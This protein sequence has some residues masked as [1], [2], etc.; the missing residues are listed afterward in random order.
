M[1]SNSLL[2]LSRSKIA[3]NESVFEDAIRFI[4][5]KKGFSPQ[6]LYQKSPREL[7]NY[8]SQIFTN[9]ITEGFKQEETPQ[10]EASETVRNALRENVFVFSGMKTYQE[11]KEASL[12]LV[13]DKG[14]IKPF[15]QFKEDVKSVYQTYN[16]RYLEA[17]YDFAVHSSAMAARWQDFEEDAEE[18]DLQYRTAG[19]DKVRPEHAALNGI[20][21][22]KNDPFW[23]EYLPPNGWECRCTTVQVRKGKY[24]L[25]NPEESQ[26]LGKAA[27]T[28]KGK[29]GV[30][31]AAMFRFNSGKTLK[32]FPHKHPYFARQSS[33]QDVKQAQKVVEGMSK[34]IETWTQVETKKGKVRIS[35][36]HGKEEERENIKIA[37][38]LAN[39]HR[40]EIDLIAKNDKVK[41]SRLVQQNTEH[42]SGIQKECYSYPLGH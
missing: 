2:T 4:H 38:Y 39:K 24:P 42:V 28:Q 6:D 8:L 7:V 17:E 32:I 3:F 14:E 37:T 13:T 19:D 12:L 16:E 15:G 40:Y 23:N 9:S 30:N 34:K 35:S 1:Y 31:K 29:D 5:E 26:E 36:L 25:S 27:T 41:D 22:P 21:L 11:L 33:P 18:Y 20:T 10:Y